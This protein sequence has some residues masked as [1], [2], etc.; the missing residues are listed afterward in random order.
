MREFCLRARED[1]TGEIVIDATNT[2]FTPLE[3]IALL[4]LKKH[5]I[6]RQVDNPNAYTRTCIDEDGKRVEIE[7]TG[8]SE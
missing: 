6:M 7:Y 5:D 3:L 8:D 4:D 2:G 1:D